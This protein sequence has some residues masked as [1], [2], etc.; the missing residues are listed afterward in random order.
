MNQELFSNSMYAR[1]KRGELIGDAERRHRN[2]T[3]P[4]HTSS[5]RS[6]SAHGTYATEKSES[7]NPFS[8][9]DYLVAA[10]LVPGMLCTATVVDF[11]LA[12]VFGFAWL[13]YVVG[14]IGYIAY[15]GSKG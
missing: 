8:R 9:I 4:E 14:R 11:R 3:L 10:A 12:E 2:G 1:S 7:L 15:K 13:G 5:R 6:R